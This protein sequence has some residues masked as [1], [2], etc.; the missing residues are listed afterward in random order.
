[1]KRT[2]N[3]LNEIAHENG[4]L[5]MELNESQRKA[6]KNCLLDMLKDILRVCDKHNLCI[7]LSG[8]SCLGAVRHKGFIP[9]DD[10]ID[11]MM[12]RSDYEKFKLI[13]DD[14]LGKNY[15][16]SVPNA[17]KRS[18]VGASLNIFKKNTLL[19]NR[20]ERFKGVCIDVFP[21]D[22]VPDNEI[23][24]FFKSRF[25]FLLR[26]IAFSSLLYS[27]RDPWLVKVT[28][29]SFSFNIYYKLL[30]FIGFVFSFK[31]YLFWLDLFDK[32][33]QERK[34]TSRM[35]LPTG[36]AM[37]DGEMLPVNVFM[38]V[39]KG[40]FEGIE[41]SLPNNTH[42]YLRNLYGNYMQIPPVEKRERHF[43]TS[44]DLGSESV[45]FF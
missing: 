34:V 27:R 8:G 4:S 12:P 31:S 13:L 43:Y 22:Y 19:S 21:I 9:W 11:L 5:F 15:D 10:D 7:M 2:S 36:R 40:V 24:R 33:I 1:M 30:L 32:F 41:V 17:K 28:E 35:T 29:R 44:F 14:E 20:G 42:V 6:L 25:S 45:N 18:I 16:F 37:Y 39:S 26:G 23:C 3:Y 38:P